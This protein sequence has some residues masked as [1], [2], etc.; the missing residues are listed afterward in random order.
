[1]IKTK[2]IIS[3]KGAKGIYYCLLR[4]KIRNRLG[5]NYERTLSQMFL[6]NKKSLVDLTNTKIGSSENKLCRLRAKNKQTKK[7]KCN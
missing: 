1:M 5:R 3:K 6:K 4:E 7:K 2:I